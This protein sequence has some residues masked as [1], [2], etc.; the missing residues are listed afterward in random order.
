VQVYSRGAPPVVFLPARMVLAYWT[1][2][3]VRSLGG[4]LFMAGPRAQRVS[5]QSLSA[6]QVRDGVK[7]Y[8]LAVLRPNKSLM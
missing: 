1:S 7:H 4:P 5:S 8:L 3:L 2:T 6:Y